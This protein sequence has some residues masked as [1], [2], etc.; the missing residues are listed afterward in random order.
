MSTRLIAHS[1]DLRRLRAEGYTLRVAGGKLVVEDVS[2]VDA[3]AVVHH[4]GMLV[5]PLALAGNKT[6]PP[7]DHTASFVGGVPCDAGGAPLTKIINNTDRAELGDG[8]IA[9]C[10]FS[11]KRADGTAYPDYYEKVTTYVAHITSQAAEIDPA[12]TAKPFR[13]VAV[14]DDEPGPFHYAD[15]ASSRVGIDAISAKLTGERIGIVGL[16]GTG[17]YVLDLVAKTPVDKIH[18]FDGDA[19]LSHNAFR[20]PGAPSLEQLGAVPNKV[21]HLASVY[22]NMHRGITAHPVPIDASNAELLRD[23]TFVFVAVDD[24]P[25]KKAIIDALIEFEVPFVDVGMGV[26]AIEGSLSGLVRTTIGTPGDTDH[27]GNHISF[28]EGH[29]DDDYRT[30]IQ[31]AELNA[32]NATF[33]V[34]MWKKLRGFYADLGGDRHSTY[35]ISTNHI[36]T[37]PDEDVDE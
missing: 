22:G 29:A 36:V 5:M 33:A 24:G 8:L 18:L 4:D 2:F 23:L 32:M 15:T 25:A 9:A 12:A 10:Y 28:A 7:P 34:V 3:D 13:P 27:I 21:D 16:G 26:Q 19:M 30:N 35:S 6:T 37:D 1:D 17:S 14:G 31:I 20:A 11:A